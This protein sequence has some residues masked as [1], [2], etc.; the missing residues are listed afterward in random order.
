M[1]WKFVSQAARSAGIGRRHL[2]AQRNEFARQPVD[3]G[4]LAH[5]GLVEMI[6]Q[7]FGKAGLD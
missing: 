2:L 6:Y 1:R 4:L 3:L 7:V 5:D